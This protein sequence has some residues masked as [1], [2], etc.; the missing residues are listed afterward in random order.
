MN[1]GAAVF[2]RA[3]RFDFEGGEDDFSAC[4]VACLGWPAVC[5]FTMTS[6]CIGESFQDVPFADIKRVKLTRQRRRLW[7]NS[8]KSFQF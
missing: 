1:L 4:S 6:N 5:L 3:A 2:L 8:E 7:K